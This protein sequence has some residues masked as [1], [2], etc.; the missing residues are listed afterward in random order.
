MATA[1]SLTSAEVDKVL[2]YISKQANAQRNRTM[3][4]ITMLAGL[5]VSEVAG[6]TIGDVRNADGTVKTE[7]Y[8][9]AERVKHGH[10]R[11]IFINQRLQTEIAEYIAERAW[12]FES[13]PLF[14]TNRGLRHAFSANTLTQ[15]FHYLYTDCDDHRFKRLC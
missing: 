3:F 15:H 12:L 10:A 11:T 5:R 9:S 4:C 1:K 2:S 6:L 14:C 7:I 8:L 13:Q